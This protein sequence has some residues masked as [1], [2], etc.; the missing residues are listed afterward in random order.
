M[1]VTPKKSNPVDPTDGMSQ[2]IIVG[3]G[4]SAGGVEALEQLFEAMPCQSGMSFVVVQHL[5]PHFESLMPQILSRRTEMKVVKI[6][7]GMRIEPNQIYVLPNGKVTQVDGKALVLQ[8][9][10]RA[11]HGYPIDFFFNSL[12]IQAGENAVAVVLSGTGSDG[13]EGVC[14]IHEQNGLVIVQSENS[15]KF[16]GMPRAAIATGVVDAIV[17]VEDIP[18]TLQQFVEILTGDGR[19]RQSVFSESMSV[20]KQI[21]NLLHTRF[22]ID[23]EQ[24]KQGLVGRRVAR[25]MSLSKLSDIQTYLDYLQQDDSAVSE[26]YHDLLIGVTEFFRDPQAFNELQL[27]V[28]PALINDVDP[29]GQLRVWVVPCATGEEAY[30]VAILIDELLSQRKL[31]LDVKIFATDVN[32]QC[33]EFAG[34]GVFPKN[35]MNNVSKTRLQNYFVEHQDGFQI[36]PR[37][38]KQIIFATHN[39]LT[40]APFTKLNLVCC[41]NLLIYLKPE[42]KKKALSLFN[43]ALGTDGVLFLGPSESAT[44]LDSAF[45][46]IDSDWQIYRKAHTVRFSQVGMAIGGKTGNPIVETPD[47]NH[48]RELLPAYDS[49]LAEYIPSGVLIDQHNQILHVF[50]NAYEFIR[51]KPGRNT[52]DLIDLLP[53]SFSVAVSN[54]LRRTKIENQT[55]VYSGLDFEHQGELK[56]Y[57][58]AIKP[59]TTQWTTNYLISIEELAT[60]TTEVTPKALRDGSLRRLEQELQKTRESLHDTILKLKSA[61][62]ELQSTNEELIASNEELQST[63]EELHSVNEELYTVNAEHQRKI[64]QLTE[65]TDDMDNLLDSLQVDT[66]YL[67]S[68]LRVRKFTLGIA[69]TFKLMPQ[70]IGRDFSSFNHELLHADIVGRIKS[71]LDSKQPFDEEVEDSSGNWYLMR[72]LPYNSR[73]TIDGALLTLI[74]ITR[75]K[76]AEQRLIELSEIVQSSDDAIFKVSENGIIR[77]WNQGAAHLFMHQPEYVIGK[78]IDVLSLDEQSAGIVAAAIQQ[79]GQGTKV[80]HVDLKATRRNGEEFDVQSTISPIYAPDGKLDGAS[81]ILRDI[82]G[83]KKAEGQIREEVRRRDHFLAVLSHELRNPAAAITNALAL[84]RIPDLEKDRQTAAI[85]IIQRH[86]GQLGKLLDDLLHVSRVTHNKFKLELKPMDIVASARQVIECIEHQ[87][88][89]KQQSLSVEFP[90]ESVFLMG[91][92]TRIVQAQTNLLVNAIKY[93]PPQGQIGYSI[94]Q[95][96]KSV[97]IEVKDNGEGMSL[98]LLQ[99]IFEVF[100]QADQSLDRSKGGMGLGLPLVKMIADAHGGKIDAFS[101]GQGHGSRFLLTL[102]TKISDVPPPK[103]LA[104][105]GAQHCIEGRRLLIVEDNTGAREMLAEFLAIEGANVETAKNGISGLEKFDE[106]H[107]EIC[108]VD[109]G[110]PDLDG[111]EVARRICQSDWDPELLVAL[112][113]YGQA[114]D[115]KKVAS[116]GFDLHLVKPIAPEALVQELSRHIDN[117]FVPGSGLGANFSN[118]D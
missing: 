63:N 105:Q 80:D 118:Q 99:Q 32:G 65:L 73:G 100:V 3:I 15:C 45:Q 27:R 33:V 69:N 7:D 74:D 14:Q 56:R 67:D 70:D 37:I 35:R 82:T 94:W 54:G 115:R 76:A 42:A 1:D 87:L 61:N 50:G 30:T 86:S 9:L 11:H 64:T 106:F 21:H 60:E 22:G 98:E 31:E 97:K 85:D 62:E 91:D 83:Q 96:G 68:D 108:I 71:V 47:S 5:S 77:T 107:P 28:L 39:L 6:K 46:A 101:D 81:I 18:D 95:E 90:N 12:A 112:T 88:N 8:D 66:I 116:A 20:E 36:I 92:E 79:I 17:P 34:K 93:T 41:R 102:P 44:E 23:F 111:F 75:I 24:Y 53:D 19:S 72:L 38:R 114:S 89:T 43:F 4:A 84:L 51:F 25:R 57:K 2:H 49:L 103:G 40:D 78:H 55:V 104:N 110:L 113:G 117:P 13:S 52:E 16:N 48:L 109:I 29:S 26:L 10:D 59:V 58:L